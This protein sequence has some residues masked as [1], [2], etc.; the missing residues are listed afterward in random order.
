MPGVYMQR[1]MT[2]A[3]ARYV[4]KDFKTLEASGVRGGGGCAVMQAREVAK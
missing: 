3:D 4:S 1:A 2:L